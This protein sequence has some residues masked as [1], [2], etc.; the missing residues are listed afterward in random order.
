MKLIDSASVADLFRL[1]VQN[2]VHFFPIYLYFVNQVNKEVFEG[3]SD[4]IIG[5]S[6]YAERETDFEEFEQEVKS[7]VVQLI[8]LIQTIID[9]RENREWVLL[10]FANI[11]QNNQ[12]Q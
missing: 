3:M 9:G 1:C 6:K 12:I 10:Q 11:T 4:K 5:Q 8:S 7:F 2:M